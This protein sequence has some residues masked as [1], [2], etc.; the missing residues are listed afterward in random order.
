MKNEPSPER[1]PV[2]FLLLQA[3]TMVSA[4]FNCALLPAEQ[5]AAEVATEWVAPAASAVA[6]NWAA[7]GSQWQASAAEAMPVYLTVGPKSWNVFGKSGGPLT[8]PAGCMAIYVRE[9]SGSPDST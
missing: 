8:G 2:C 3:S 4:T 9:D 6:S 7:S 5:G 1:G